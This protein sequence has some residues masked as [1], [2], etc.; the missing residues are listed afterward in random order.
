MEIVVRGSH[1]CT[2]GTVGDSCVARAHHCGWTGVR[3]EY[4]TTSEAAERFHFA[5]YRNLPENSASRFMPGGS[6]T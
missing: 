6:L 5:R 4:G 3:S 1:G 2:S